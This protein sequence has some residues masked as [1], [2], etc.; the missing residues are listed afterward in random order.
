MICGVENPPGVCDDPD[1]DPDVIDPA[2][3]SVVGL[4]EPDLYCDE[5]FL[6]VWRQRLLSPFRVDGNWTQYRVDAFEELQRN[7]SVNMPYTTSDYS[8][9]V[10]TPITTP[11]ATSTANA[12]PTCTFD[13]AS[14]QYICPTAPSSCFGQIV[15]PNPELRGCSAVADK[16]HVST[17][18]VRVATGNDYCI[19]EKQICLPLPC[20]TK[21]I[22]KYRV[23]C[24]DTVKQLSNSTHKVTQ[25]QFMGW[26]PCLVGSCDDMALG[27]R[28][29]I[30]YVA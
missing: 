30:R 28:I 13:L 14:G 19:F 9:Y 7:C 2:L 3:Q 5:C 11:S 23:S 17:G 26:N 10:G 27:Q 6:K 20:E 1:F 12:L 22:T 15:E 16:Y 24:S 21:T 4:Y 29:C 18:D 25:E 8:L